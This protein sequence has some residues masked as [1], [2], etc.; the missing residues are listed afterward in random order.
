LSFK[1]SAARG[2]F[3]FYNGG[4]DEAE[5]H[6]KVIDFMRAGKLN[7][8]HWL[9]LDAPFALKNIGEA[10]DALRERKL[11]KALIQLSAE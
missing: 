11:I 5:T 7:A 8:A 1:P 4:Y 2:T 6:D 10:F 3:T 9:N